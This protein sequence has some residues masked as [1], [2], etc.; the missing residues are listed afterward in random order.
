MKPTQEFLKSIEDQS[1]V[2]DSQDLEKLSI[3]FKYLYEQ[4][5]L[6]NLTSVVDPEEAWMRH[7][8]DSLT[9]LPFLIS[10]NSRSVLDLGSG[11]GFPGIPLAIAEPSI[12][13]TLLEATLKKCNFLKSAC[14]KVELQNVVVCSDRAEN[15]GN[16]HGK[17]RNK[18]DAVVA[19]AVGG[20][21]VLLELSIPLIRPGGFLL[22][23]K[24][25]K[26]KD[27]I[28]NA[29]K[30]LKVLNSEVVDVHWSKTG[31]IVII[32]KTGPTP[33]HFPRRPGEPK[34]EP[35]K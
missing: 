24:G 4:N 20:L 21:P 10:I 26:A 25:Q 6:F 30:A 5:K 13:F 16:V 17:F 15:V 11:G 34:R 8:Y 22:A 23:I 7:F 35:L 32:E 2:W 33:A 19:R 31:R 18:F 12:H 9:L 14:E 28:L 27:E 29:S 1:I 3:F